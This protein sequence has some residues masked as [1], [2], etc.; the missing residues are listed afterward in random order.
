MTVVLGLMRTT[1]L[2]HADVEQQHVW[3]RL[4]HELDDVLGAF[5][6]GNDLEVVL[7]AEDRAE[8]IAKERVIIDDDDAA[9]AGLDVHAI[10]L[11]RT[12]SGC[13]S[14]ARAGTTT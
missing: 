3:L 11:L 2:R 12:D 13:G 5:D 10:L 6:V 4:P 1:A 14:W 9:S 8:A 7:H